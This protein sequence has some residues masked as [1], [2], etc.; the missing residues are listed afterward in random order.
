MYVVPPLYVMNDQTSTALAVVVEGGRTPP[1]YLVPVGQAI[2][3]PPVAS[4]MTMTVN[5]NIWADVGGLVKV[6]VVAPLRVNWKILE[7][8]R[9]RVAAPVTPEDTAWYSR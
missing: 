7:V 5:E 6:I 3:L 1:E 4:W 8:D 2:V 9:S